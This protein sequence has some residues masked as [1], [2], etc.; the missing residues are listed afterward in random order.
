[1]NGNIDARYMSRPDRV[2]API[3]GSA[4]LRRV[5]ANFRVLVALLAL[6][7]AASRPL[8]SV[9][10][11]VAAALVYAAYAVG[12]WG[13]EIANR[14]VARGRMPVWGDVAAILTLAALAGP[15]ANPFVLL[16]F[17]P[18][19]LAALMYGFVA[20]VQVSI[21]ASFAAGG[22]AVIR[23][24]PLEA[25][26]HP[27]ILHPLA[28][29]LIGPLV[30]GLARTG[31]RRSEQHAI[32]ERLLEQADPR[33]GVRRIAEILLQALARHHD[34]ELGVLLVWLADGEPRVFRCDAAGRVR[35]LSGAL[36]TMLRDALANLPPDIA[37]VHHVAHLFGRIPVRYR[38][39]FHVGTQQPTNAGRHAMQELADA[40]DARSLV[41]V[42]LCRRSPHPCRLVFESGRR[43]FGPRS[44]EVLAGVME[45]LGPVI[46]NAAL[47]ER[48]AD[49]AIA[50]ER[51]RIGRDL[52]D[53]AIQPY[54]GLK[55][56]IEALAR[57]AMPDNPLYR[58]IHALQDVAVAELHQ[59]RELVSGMR[60]DGGG[61]DNA[62]VPALRRQARRFGELFGLDVT[63]HCD[64]EPHVGR[65]LA[66]EI[67]PMVSEAL[68]NIRRHTTATHAEIRVGESGAQ[69]VLHVTNSHDPLAPPAPFVPRS[70]AERAESIGGCAVVDLCAPGVTDLMISIPRTPRESDHDN[71]DRKPDQSVSCR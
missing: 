32:V 62:L 40:L 16:L 44:A 63:V 47:L 51:A 5:L 14:P 68:T 12:L 52:H 42:P 30:A 9:P 45:Q 56:G 13:M 39:G 57:K 69:Y 36:G 54:L 35:E 55:Y 15:Q 2:R 7:E 64:D 48:L 10:L 53:S 66:A 33:L 1:M 21:V 28:L 11:I 67:Y 25:L 60:C 65:R 71:N 19:L 38:S 20:G 49:E 50:T 59:L 23:G 70:I 24:E 8:S 17:F 26:S 29:L 46:E 18:V 58:D 3:D 37:N 43:R 6:A 31:T 61:A 34:A 41:A 22:L 27:A 4:D